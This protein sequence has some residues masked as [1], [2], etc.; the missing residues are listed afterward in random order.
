MCIKEAPNLLSVII[1]FTINFLLLTIKCYYLFSV[2]STLADPVKGWIDNFNG[3][4]GMLIGGGKGILRVIL[5]D[6]SV[7]SDFM[8]VDLAVKAILITAW[9][10]GIKT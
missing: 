6:S 8:P 1:F 9:K 3:P 5:S 10:R 7:M 4:F 2:V